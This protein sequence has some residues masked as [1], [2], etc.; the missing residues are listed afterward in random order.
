MGVYERNF[1]YVLWLH[2]ECLC[3]GAIETKYKKDEDLFILNSTIEDGINVSFTNV[4]VMLF[5]T[6]QILPF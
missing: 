2:V 3:F 5:Y 1:H 4:L 6:F